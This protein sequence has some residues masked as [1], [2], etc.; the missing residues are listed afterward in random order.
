MW[1]LPQW[2]Y[3]H[4][5][6][7]LN[8][9]KVKIEQI[10]NEII[11]KCKTDDELKEQLTAVNEAERKLRYL[12]IQLATIHVDRKEEQRKAREQRQQNGNVQQPPPNNMLASVQ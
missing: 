8:E 6:T 11:H 10:R 12:K 5:K 9:Q 3:Q 7:I 4:W 2:G 1:T